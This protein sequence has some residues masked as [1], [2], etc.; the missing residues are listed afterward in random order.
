MWRIAIELSQARGGFDSSASATSVWLNRSY[1]GAIT[2]P[3]R[4]NFA[5]QGDNDRFALTSMIH[6]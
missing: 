5:N 3:R 1:S 2:R 6:T 4:P